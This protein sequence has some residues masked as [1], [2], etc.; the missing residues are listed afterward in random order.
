MLKQG[1]I[2]VTSFSESSVGYAIP[3]DTAI[4]CFSNTSHSSSFYN[5]SGEEGI[6][7]SHVLMRYNIFLPFVSFFVYVE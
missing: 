1:R 3:L 7:D 4:S 6:L 5:P 2:S